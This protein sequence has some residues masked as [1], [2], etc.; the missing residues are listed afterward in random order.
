[1]VEKSFQ[2]LK[3]IIERPILRLLDFNKHFQVCCDASGTAIGAIH[4]QEDKCV[5]YFSENLNDGRQ[6]YSSYGK[7][8]YVVV[9]AL[10]HWR[11]YFLC[12]EFVLFSDN[13]ALQYIMQQ[14][15]LNHK[16]AKWVEYLQSY[17]FLLKYISGHA[18]RVA[19]ALSRR[20]LL[21]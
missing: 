12:N 18:N 3:K 2:I 20:A 13:S 1:V 8:F 11:H 9:Q 7:E 6:K 19:D 17:T 5:A 21:L 14:H 15:R 10:K 16:H 4:S